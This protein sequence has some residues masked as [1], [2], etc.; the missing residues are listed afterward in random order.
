MPTTTL[1]VTVAATRRARAGQEDGLVR[2]ADELC[3][4]AGR[5]AAGVTCRVDR[6]RRYGS[7]TVTVV[8]T[9]PSAAQAHAWERSPE[10]AAVLA[11]GDALTDGAPAA[12]ALLPGGAAGPRWRTTL[13]VWAG[14]FPFALAVNLA[15]G[16]ALDRLPVLPRTLVTTAVLVPLAV[17]VGIP[18]VTWLLARRDPRRGGRSRS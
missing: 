14:L 16:G 18:A 6:R 12:P 13:I 15:A 7:V 5:T 11:R 4:A 2:W 3:A 10:R 9:F 1:P 17:Y 8:V